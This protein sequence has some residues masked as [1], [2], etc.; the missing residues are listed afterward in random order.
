MNEM[1]VIQMLEKND[2]N[3]FFDLRLEALQNSPTSFLSSYKDEKGLGP[4]MYESILN[5]NEGNDNVIFGAIMQ[6]NFIGI[7]G[8]YREQK[9]KINHK[10]NIWGMYVKPSYRNKGIGKALL[11]KV[12]HHARNKMDCSLINISVEETN[13]A[14]KNLYESFGFTIWGTEVKA[15]QVNGVFYS[16]HH[17]SLLI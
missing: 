10:A 15:M 3:R 17:M 14:A 13:A 5:Q 8:I 12:L 9:S 1:I 7:I 11:E 6:D 4:E 16:E 2:L